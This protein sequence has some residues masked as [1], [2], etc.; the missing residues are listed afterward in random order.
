[1]RFSQLPRGHVGVRLLA[2]GTRAWT[3]QLPWQVLVPRDR[4]YIQEAWHAHATTPADNTL[5]QLDI[6]QTYQVS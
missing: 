5:V 3:R 6:T 1:M 4:Q 2:R